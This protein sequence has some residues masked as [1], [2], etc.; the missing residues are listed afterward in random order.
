MIDIPPGLQSK[1]DA[2]VTTLAR[3]WIVTRRDGRV[4]GFTDHD[5][6]LA[7]AG[8][9]CRPDS[10]FAAGE[11]RA[12]AGFSAARGAVFGAL[13]D[14]AIEDA[15]LDAGLWDE[16][17]VEIHAVDWSAPGLSFR[18][19]TGALGAVKRTER[20]YEAELEGLSARLDRVIGRRFSKRCDAELG[21]A[22]CGAD[23]S[24]AGFSALVSVV[25]RPGAT[26]LVV[27]GA[28]QTPG[29]FSNGVLSWTGGANAGRRARIRVHRADA[30]GALIEL[31]DASVD[32]VTPGDTAE[33]FAGCDKRFETCGSKFANALNFRGCPHMPG[34]DVLMRHAGSESVR[35]GR[36]R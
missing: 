17:R 16:A 34:N 22:R 36:A 11:I 14:G 15:A 8:I 31:E 12:E 18:V 25:A 33:L 5:G 7:V 26:A 35:D 27:S 23:L 24:G 19:F 13:K 6:P 21:D 1:L 9:P 3:A 4:F 32:S 2:G 10:G 20:G 28:S 30:R 29:W